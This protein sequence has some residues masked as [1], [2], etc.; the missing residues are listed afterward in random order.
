MT[1]CLIS[2]ENLKK[3]R[4]FR[5]RNIKKVHS[6]K[7]CTFLS[8]RTLAIRSAFLM[9][10]KVA[11]ICLRPFFVHFEKFHCYI[12]NR[13]I[14]SC[15]RFINPHLPIFFIK[16]SISYRFGYMVFFY[17]LGAVKIGYRTRYTYQTVV[18]AC[19]KTELL[20]CRLK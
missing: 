12:N 1:K 18:S 13:T 2:A 7:L 8:L 16:C 19:R 15:R 4:G 5:R 3:Q 10:L 17:H 11:V 9:T 6:N 14:P 20:V